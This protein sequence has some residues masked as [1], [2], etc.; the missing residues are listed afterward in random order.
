[1]S[2]QTFFAVTCTRTSTSDPVSV[3]YSVKADNGDNA[4]GVNNRGKHSDGSALRYDFYTSSSCSTQWKG[5][6]RISDTITWSGGSTGAITKQTS[7]WV[8]V[9]SA[10]TVT[11][12]GV[13]SDSVGLT[14]TD[15]SNLTLS[16]TALVSIFAPA[17]CTVT[18]PPRSIALGYT[19]FGPQ[20]S[21]TTSI[22]V[23]CTAGMPYV[24]STDT[25]EAVLSG[26]R[27]VLSPGSVS[28]NGSGALQTHTITA[29]VPGGQ[30][31]TCASGACNAT[32][33]HTL[34]ISY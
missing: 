23:T 2:V 24:V 22:G 33:T 14:L 17:L 32:R 12:S 1:M 27:Y 18:S 15:S 3:S 25:A 21:G 4:N 8:C 19:A 13:Y 20:V 10:Q 9:V 30:A 5:G 11:S 31:G 28:S 34:T 26:L 7:F 29:T 6:T 16:A